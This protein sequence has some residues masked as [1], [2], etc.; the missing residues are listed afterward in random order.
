MRT[1]G[2]V[3]RVAVGAA[4]GVERAALLFAQQRG[5]AHDLAQRLVQLVRR[6]EREDLQRLVAA[7][8]GLRLRLQ[9][10]VA[11]REGLGGEP[12][13]LDLAGE[14]HVQRRRAR[15]RQRPRDHVEEGE[16]RQPRGRRGGELEERREAGTRGARTATRRSRGSGRSSR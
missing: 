13:L 11:A 2:V 3:H 7:R 6:R 1:P 14:R 10:L 15:Q 4:L 8:E 9:R 16:H 12:S 5:E